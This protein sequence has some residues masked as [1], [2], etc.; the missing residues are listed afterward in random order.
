MY[1]RQLVDCSPRPFYIIFNRHSTCQKLTNHLTIQEIRPLQLL[2]I[3]VPYC[4]PE[5]CHRPPQQL[6]VLSFTASGGED[7]GG[8]R[9]LLNGGLNGSVCIGDEAGGREVP[10]K[11]PRGRSIARTAS[12]DAYSATAGGRRSL[13]PLKFPHRGDTQYK[14]VILVALL[15]ISASLCML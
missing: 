13:P 5:H 6:H 11:R 10:R 9:L 15:A 3:S 7:E 4:G 2:T 12:L 14:S 1:P 8:G